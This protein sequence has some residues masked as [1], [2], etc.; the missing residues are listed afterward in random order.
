MSKSSKRGRAVR[1]DLRVF[2]PEYFDKNLTW[3]MGRRVPIKLAYED[4]ELKRIALAAQKAGYE[5]FLDSDKHFSKTWYDGKGRMM[6]SKVGTKEEQIREIAR[7]IPKVNLPKPTQ[8]VKDE[9]KKPKKGS[10]Y[11]QKTR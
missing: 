4:P 3:R 10:V 11:R 7:Q 8:K 6:V 5:V 1:K 2:Y 9:S